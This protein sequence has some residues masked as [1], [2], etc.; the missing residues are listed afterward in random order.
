MTPVS[1]TAVIMLSLAR[2]RTALARAGNMSCSVRF[3]GRGFGKDVRA[4]A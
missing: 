1:I 2:S 3:S 4:A